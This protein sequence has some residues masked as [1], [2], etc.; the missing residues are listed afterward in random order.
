VTGTYG[1]DAN[2]NRTSQSGTGGTSAYGYLTGTNRLQ[3][4]SGAVNRSYSYDGAGNIVADGQHSYAYD[5]TNRL[6]ALDGGQ[7]QYRYN[8]LG[9]RVQKTGSTISYAAWD[10]QGRVI[11][12]YDAGGTVQE[13]V[14]VGT[15]PVAVIQA[16]VA[17]S[18]DAD[19]VDAPRVIRGPSGLVAW[20]WDTDAF[21]AAAA[22]A[23]PSG[24]G[25]FDYNGR[26]PGQLFDAETGKHYNGFRD[27][28][29]ATGRY[30]QSDP[31]GL[32]GGINTYTYVAGNPLAYVDPMGLAIECKTV[33]KL[34]FFDVQSCTENGQTPSEQSAKDAKRMSDK[35]LDKACKNN[36]YEDAH[37]MKRD[38]GYGKET[39]IYA[40]KDGNMYAGPRKGTGTPQYIHMNTS[41]IVPKP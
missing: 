14:Y 1:Y 18:V 15:T 28:D 17:Y 26:F 5:A 30:V 3:S 9:Q 11:G 34:P 38:L 23:N 19:Q 4:I 16:G 37:D 25:A 10:E 12:E 24:A 8:G 2:G 27:Y 40:D 31:I 33:L 35:E 36:G 41:G 6:S 22:N 32:A 21:G 39:D 13:T 20:R 29:P 7:T